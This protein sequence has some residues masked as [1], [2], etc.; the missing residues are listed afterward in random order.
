NML[1]KIIPGCHSLDRAG[2]NAFRA[3]VTIGVGP[4]RGRFQ[5]L[6]KLSELEPPRSLTLQ[7]DLTGPLGAGRGTGHVRLAPGADAT[8]VGYA[9]EPRAAGKGAAVGGRMLEATMRALTRLF[10]ERLIGEATG[11]PTPT[12]SWWRRLLGLPASD[13][14]AP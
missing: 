7:G 1:A 9:Y 13:R 5:A 8:R 12:V 10:F 2:P 3:A 14:A 11:A 6:V 4:V